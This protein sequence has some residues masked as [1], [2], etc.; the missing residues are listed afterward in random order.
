[1]SELN[2]INNCSPTLAGLKTG[3][4]FNYAIQDGEDVYSSVAA[5]N[6]VLKPKGLRMEV[7]RVKDGVALIYLF[8]TS[9]LSQDLSSHTTKEFLE[10]NDY[11]MDSLSSCLEKLKQ[12]INESNEFPHEIGLFIGYPMED[13]KGFIEKGAKGSKYCG[14]WRVYGDVE[15]AKKKFAIYK[16]CRDIYRSI[17]EKNNNFGK[18]IISK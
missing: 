4:I 7:L 12:R 11:P 10:E 5:F 6:M 3:N 14:A 13:V 8:R 15:A 1:M 18:L 16:K 17:Y 9:A 2:I